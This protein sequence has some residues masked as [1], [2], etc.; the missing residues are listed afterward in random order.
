MIQIKDFNLAFGSQIIFDD[1][2]QTINEYDRIGLVGRNGSGKSTLL[3]AISN[4]KMLDSG[5]V[6]I[7]KGKTFAYLPQEVVMNS[8]KSVIDEAFSTFTEIIALQKIIADGDV[9][10][11]DNQATPEMLD[12]YSNATQ[13]LAELDPESA[14][15]ESEEILSGLGFSAEQMKQPVSSL[16]TGWQMR[17]VLAKLLLQKADFYLFDEP[18]NHLDLFAKEWFLGFL[19]NAP[20][21]FMLVCHE[22]Y[23]LDELCEEIIAM[24]RGQ[25]TR[26]VG[27]FSHYEKQYQEDLERLI[28]ARNQ[29]QKD[30]A[31][32]K[33]T[34]ERFRASATKAKMAQKLLREVEATE[35]IELPPA[36]SNVRF[37]F[38]EPPR[39]GRITLEVKNVSHSFGPKELFRNVNFEIERGKKVALVAPNGVGKT[40]LFNL[41]VNNIKLQHGDIDF[42]HNVK[43]AI[44]AQDQNKALAQNLSILDNAERACKEKTTHEIRNLLGAFLFPGKA[45]EKTIGVLSG[46]EK[47]RVA[48]AITLLQNANLLLLDEP[49]N[50]LD[51]TSKEI[52]LRALQQYQG[53]ILFVSHDRDFINDLATDVIELNTT[54]AHWYHGNYDAFVELKAQSAHRHTPAPDGTAT[55]GKESSA[56]AQEHEKRKLINKHERTIEKLEKELEQ[57]YQKFED[58]EYGSPE[59][60]QLQDSITALQTKKDAAA[61]ELAAVSR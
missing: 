16:S 14:L 17:L 2:C 33:E 19:Q 39:S 31:R 48:M 28:A 6:S 12:Q 49:T 24:D 36:P 13:K 44:F 3:K 7:A 55:S 38:P 54:G 60:D 4:P 35:M 52:L 5:T 26:Y 22:R 34:A 23:F 57:L 42:G 46:G 30:I 9:K 21:G 8:D 56:S 40:T 27:N 32:K 59:F 10:I 45:V 50:H 25:A 11:A 53:T 37:T 58:I 41:I 18:T 20:F 61:K 29:Q 1:V 43:Y 15:A 47:N 51:I